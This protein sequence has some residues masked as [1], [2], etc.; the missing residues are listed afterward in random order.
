MTTHTPSG[1]TQ[2][3]GNDT[4]VVAVA[5][6]SSLIIVPLLVGGIAVSLRNQSLA[7]ECDGKTGSPKIKEVS[8]ILKSAN[9]AY[10]IPGERAN[11]VVFRCGRNCVQTPLWKEFTSGLGKPASATFC[12]EQL[13]GVVVDGLR[14]K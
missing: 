5:V 10:I 2:K 13:L 14:L 9:G 4:D 11:W 3:S 8:G 7:A 6:I 12:N 1:T